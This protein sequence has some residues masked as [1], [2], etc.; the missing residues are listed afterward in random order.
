MP[1]GR[2]R[3]AA[4][5]QRR[6]FQAGLAILGRALARAVGILL[7]LARLLAATLL[8]RLLTRVLVLL[9]RILVLIGHSQSPLLN[10]VETNALGVRLFLLEPGSTL[11]FEWP[12]LVATMARE[13]AS[14]LLMYNAFLPCL[15]LL[16]LAVPTVRKRPDASFG[17]PGPPPR[18]VFKRAFS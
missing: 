4:E 18:K 1:F 16:P 3:R 5:F 7:L 12:L 10:A 2:A 8:A 14:K 13:L 11:I 6:F 17:L 15:D 9:S